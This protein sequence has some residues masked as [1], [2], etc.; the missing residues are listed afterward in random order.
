MM[1]N[2]EFFVK[3]CV[4]SMTIV[5]S[6]GFISEMIEIDKDRRYT[7]SVTTIKN[8]GKMSQIKC[9]CECLSKGE[10]CCDASYDSQTHECT[11]GTSG[12]N[13]AATEIFSGSSLLL[14]T[15]RFFGKYMNT[16]INF[17]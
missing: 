7:T 16:S 13:H 12:D 11:I 9:A 8:V 10:E 3:L 6:F 17:E 4:F 1:N 15:S 2:I 5:F 14:K